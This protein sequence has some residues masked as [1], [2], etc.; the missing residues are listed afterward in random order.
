LPDI[1]MIAY[2][3]AYCLHI[4]KRL[5][6]KRIVDGK[7]YNT[8]SSTIVAEGTYKDDDQSLVIETTV[9][10]NRS[11][12]Y[13]AV[14]ANTQ[15]YRDRNGEAQ[16]R[17]WH[18]W[19]VLGDEA[20]AAAYCEKNELTIFHGFDALPEAD[21]APDDTIYVR[22]PRVLKLAVEAKAKAEDLSINAFAMR[23]L[24]RCIRPTA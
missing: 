19:D 8:A 7:T 21:D 18:Q 5:E 15:G 6:M 1:H 3:F 9:F 20:T 11:G 14:D 2:A 24:E 10:K 4:P 22:V 17:S 12:V 23:C 13:F 16:E